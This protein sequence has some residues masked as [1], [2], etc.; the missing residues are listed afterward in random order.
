MNPNELQ[1]MSDMELS[2]WQAGWKERTDKD[3]LAK[4][5]WRRRDKLEQHNLNKEIIKHQHELNLQVV[6][7]QRKIT[8]RTSL[9]VALVGFLG[10]IVGAIVGAVLQSNLQ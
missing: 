2:K 9:L 10:I 1:K 3:F 7:V 6:E 8:F 5:E 4:A